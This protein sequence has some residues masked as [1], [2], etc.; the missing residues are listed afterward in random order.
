MGFTF[1][2]TDKKSVANPL[3]EM[4]RLIE[5]DPHHR[6]AIFPY[7]GGEEMNTSPTHAHHRYVINF[8]DFPLR[9]EDLGRLWVDAE[10]EQRREW[11]RN[12]IVPLDYPKPVA[13]DWP[14]LLAIVEDRVKPKR[15]KVNRQVRRERWWQFGDRQPAL[16]EAIADMERVLAVNCGAT[17][18]LAVTF[19]PARMV[20]AN[21]L[22]VFLFDTYAAFCALQSR[23]HEIWARFL[24]FFNEGRPPLHSHR[25]LRDLP[26][27]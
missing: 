10:E 15:M 25:L 16:Y 3:A 11:L 1:D 17:P 24:R 27:P 19:L 23:P 14:N 20:F 7:I 6:E 21:S 22:D 13:V 4:Q 5:A 26:I 18:H 2:D 8:A 12:G 9:R